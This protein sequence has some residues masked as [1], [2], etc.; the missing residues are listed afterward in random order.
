[1]TII[2]RRTAMI[3]IATLAC[4]HLFLNSDVQRDLSAREVNLK[5]APLQD[6]STNQDVMRLTEA[7]Q[8]VE[9][10]LRADPRR[11]DS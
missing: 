3:G 9:I 1:M 11:L 7:G 10:T 5:P 4:S 8:D 2:D 6:V